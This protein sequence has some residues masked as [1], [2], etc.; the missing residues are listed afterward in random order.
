MKTN[1][2]Y[3]LLTLFAVYSLADCR[4]QQWMLVSMAHCVV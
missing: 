4:V 2:N 3:C 1:R